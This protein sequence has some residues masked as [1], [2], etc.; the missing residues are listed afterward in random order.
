MTTNEF[1]SIHKAED[2]ADLALRLKQYPEVDAAYA[3]VQIAG[4]QK[5]VQK[6]P[7]LANIKGWIWPKKLSM[8]QCSGEETARIKR[9]I[10]GDTYTTGADLTGGA[11]VDSYYLSERAET[12]HYVE[13]QEDLCTMAEH[14]FRLVGRPIRVHHCSAESFAESMPDVDVAFID[15]A[16]RNV[17]GGKVFKLEDCSPNLSTLLPSLLPHCK[18]LLIKLS[19]MLDISE[20]MRQ[21]SAANRAYI[22]AVRN[23]VKELLIL[24]DK[25]SKRNKESEYTDNHLI[26]AINI[27]RNSAESYSFTEAEEAAAIAQYLSPTEPVE[28]YLYEP[29]AAILKAGAFRLM[30]ERYAVRKLGINTHLYQSDELV[31]AFPGR[32][33][34]IQVVVDKTKQKLLSGQQ[35]NILTRNYPLKPDDIRKKL[36]LRDGGEQYIIGARIADKAVLLLADRIK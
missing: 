4:W 23:E 30:S 35:A 32:I 13:Q 12:W 22:I 21:L 9:Q 20:A 26:T 17:H 34:K 36:K 11:G 5:A 16:R 2:V 25:E 31:E 28:G 27:M 1:I 3:L 19:P 18:R 8:E 29:N 33:W 15:P 6:L 7:E 24:F 14:N 10:I